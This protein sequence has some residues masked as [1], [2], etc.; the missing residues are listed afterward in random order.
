MTGW[1]YQQAAQRTANPGLDSVEKLKNGVLGLAGEAGECADLVKKWAYQ[2]HDE[3]ETKDKLKEELGDVMW[4]AAETAAALGTTLDEIM[5]MNVAKLQARYPEGFDAER[6][7]HRKAAAPEVIH[8]KDCRSCYNMKEVDPL[9]PW[10]GTC[11]E[12]FYCAENDYDYYPAHYSARTYFCGD[13]KRRE[14]GL[15]RFAHNDTGE[16]DGNKEEKA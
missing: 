1:E 7:M 14:D 9:E 6:S 5:L 2:G 8:C 11:G 13:A 4:Y 3:G 12:G 10:D 16:G 15:L